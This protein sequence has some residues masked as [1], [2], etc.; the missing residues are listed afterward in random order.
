MTARRSL[1]VLLALMGLAAGS[2][3]SPSAPTPTGSIVIINLTATVEVLTTTAEPGLRYLLRYEVRETG[4][5]IGVTLLRQRFELSN[6]FATEADFSGMP[7]V[8]PGG[9]VPV[10]STLSIYAASVPASSVTFHVTYRDDRG[11]TGTATA[12]AAITPRT[13]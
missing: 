5:Q 9:T 7:R 11:R 3:S 6:G 8:E 12:S 4:G 10:V 1:V 2:C 13:S